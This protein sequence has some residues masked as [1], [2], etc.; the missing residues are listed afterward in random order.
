MAS[1]THRHEKDYG[2][3]KQK[4]DLHRLSNSEPHDQDGQQGDDRGRPKRVEQRREQG[5][6]HRGGPHQDAER[7]PDGEH[8]QT[9]DSDPAE[10]PQCG[11]EQAAFACLAVPC[12]VQQRI[13]GAPR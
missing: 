7:D 12:E 8:Q 6:G 2:T 3:E 9:R 11:H 4:R 13:R 5:V 1:R 10:R